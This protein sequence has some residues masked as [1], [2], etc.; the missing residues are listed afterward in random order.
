ME[1]NFSLSEPFRGAMLKG[2]RLEGMG[3]PHVGPSP[4]AAARGGNKVRRIRGRMKCVR[5]IPDAPILGCSLA[6]KVQISASGDAGSWVLTTHGLSRLRVRYQTWPNSPW[7]RPE[8]CQ[9]LFWAVIALSLGL[10]EGRS[11]RLSDFGGSG[12]CSRVWVLVRC[13]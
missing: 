1:L 8:K 9:R 11:R 3:V 7:D 5:G 12:R 13:L 6:S 10:L 4:I 2:F